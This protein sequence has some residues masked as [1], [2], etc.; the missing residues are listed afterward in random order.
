MVV[1]YCSRPERDPEVW[2]ISDRRD[3]HRIGGRGTN[4]FKYKYADRDLNEWLTESVD[5]R[6]N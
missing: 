5:D 4:F 6:K 1:D 2:N 3:R